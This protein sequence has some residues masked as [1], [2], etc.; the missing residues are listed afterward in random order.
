V[1]ASL[2][3]AYGRKTDP[4]LLDMMERVISRA[5]EASRI[6]PR[7]PGPLAHFLYGALCE[8]ALVVA[9]ADDQRAAYRKAVVEIGRVLDGLAID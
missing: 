6:G 2:A 9:R 1:A 7:K 4:W 8:T 5:V 3:S